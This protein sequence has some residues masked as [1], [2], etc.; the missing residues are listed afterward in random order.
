MEQRS[1]CTEVPED[2]MRHFVVE[3]TCGT[4]WC[5]ANYDPVCG[6]D[7]KTYYNPCFLYATQRCSNPSLEIKY[8][9]KCTE[10]PESSSSNLCDRV[11]CGKRRKCVVESGP[12]P[13]AHC[14]RD[15]DG[16]GHGLRNLCER[17]ECGRGRKCAVEIGPP[18][19]AHCVRDR[20][21]SRYHYG[22]YHGSHRDRDRYHLSDG[23]H[24]EENHRDRDRDRD[25]QDHRN[26]DRDR[27]DYRDREQDSD[28]KRHRDRD[29][30]SDKKDR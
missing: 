30:D 29:R 2:L 5:D 10:K 14:I 9:Q 12:P 26:R 25:Q 8:R 20:D 16:G 19:V 24:D 15:R 11:E 13:T 22:G 27:E 1:S 23:D 3:R 7:D 17:V 18:P 4:S 6:T 21:G 28:R